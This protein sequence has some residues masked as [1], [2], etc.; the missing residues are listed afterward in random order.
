MEQTNFEKFYE[1]NKVEILYNA[2]TNDLNMAFNSAYPIVRRKKKV[3]DVS[4]P[5]INS[6]L[7]SQII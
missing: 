7:K 3:L 6:G 5:Y 2:F 1:M 4:K